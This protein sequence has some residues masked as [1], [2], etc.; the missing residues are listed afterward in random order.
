[1]NAPGER[2][3]MLE[4]VAAHA[5]GVLPEADRARAIAFI[6]SDEEARREY[7]ELR[8]VADLIGLEAEAPP[9][10]LR[11]ARMKARLLASVRG[12]GTAAPPRP[13]RAVV[14]ISALAAAAA[15]ILALYGAMRNV[16][17]YAEFTD[18]DRRAT[19]LQQELTVA[20]AAVRRDARI[21]ADLSAPDAKRYAVAYGAVIT[22]RNHV[23]LAFDA[24]PALPRGRVY[25]AWTLAHGAQAVAP[26]IT[27]TPNANG[28]TLVPLPED[29]TGLSAVALSVEPSG[30]SRAPTTKP[31]FVQPL[32]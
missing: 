1:V 29:A 8:P 14:W 25:Q 9:D 11:A 22:R 13:Q 28:T 6:R 27:F 17:L 24:L 21:L 26:S 32:S 7:E 19:A 3:E 4:L 5:L 30:G 31:A 23:Y 16:T 15:L 2:D 12:T 18:A 10:A 20:R